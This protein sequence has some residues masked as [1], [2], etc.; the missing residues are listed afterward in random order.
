MKSE[1]KIIEP[2]RQ[3]R[4]SR[5]PSAAVSMRITFLTL[6]GLFTLRLASYLSGAHGPLPESEMKCIAG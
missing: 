4:R 3:P 2:W 1:T 6:A 5:N